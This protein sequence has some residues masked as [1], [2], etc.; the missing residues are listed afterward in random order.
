MMNYYR[1][2]WRNKC[3]R[4]TRR[5]LQLVSQVKG[6]SLAELSLW[7]LVHFVNVLTAPMVCKSI[8]I[9]LWTFI[10][11]GTLFFSVCSDITCRT[12]SRLI[13]LYDMAYI[14][15]F[16]SQSSNLYDTDMSLQIKEIRPTFTYR[17]TST[18]AVRSDQYQEISHPPIYT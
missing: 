15:D 4:S 18:W 10:L 6:G 13:R 11:I 5:A 12:D 9:F 7:E 2:P 17:T 16:P 1:G 14:I 8:M 3:S